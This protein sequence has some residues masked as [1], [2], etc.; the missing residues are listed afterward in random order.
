[1]IEVSAE[2]SISLFS[3]K[4]WIFSTEI[5]SN[6]TCSISTAYIFG[7]VYPLCLEVLMNMPF[8]AEIGILETI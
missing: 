1:M 7:V 3:H 6:L 5:F 4:G 2:P 8:R